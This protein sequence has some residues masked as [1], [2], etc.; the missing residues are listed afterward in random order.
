MK[1]VKTK[2]DIFNL[3]D[4]QYDVATPTDYYT[5]ATTGSQRIL[6]KEKR[7]YVI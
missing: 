3:S 2:Q 1:E 6:P 5:K 7:R 4:S